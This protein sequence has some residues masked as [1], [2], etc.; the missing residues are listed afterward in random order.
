[1]VVLGF[2]FFLNVVDWVPSRLQRFFYV[3]QGL[4]TPSS[5]CFITC[6]KVKISDLRFSKCS[7]IWLSKRES[8]SIICLN[9]SRLRRPQIVC[10][11]PSQFGFRQNTDPRSTDPLLTPYWPPYWPP[12]KSMGKW[13]L[14]KPRNIDGTW[15]K[16]I[17]KFSLPETSKMADALQI[18]DSCSP[19]T[20]GLVAKNRAHNKLEY[21]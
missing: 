8:L 21:Q 4:F 17:N 20:E 18:P 5:S 14:K 15:F 19:L 3:S 2:C 12:I 7:C 13:K 6:V 16:F 1:M 11:L 9:C 10:C